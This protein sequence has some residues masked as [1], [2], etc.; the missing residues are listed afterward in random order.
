MVGGVMG[1]E[2]AKQGSRHE[3]RKKRASLST[4]VF[5]GG[6]TITDATIT[7]ASA[8]SN[9][10]TSPAPG[11]TWQKG[12]DTA[13]L[14]CEQNL[15]LAMQQVV[16]CQTRPYCE[17]LSIQLPESGSRLKPWMPSNAFGGAIGQRPSAQRQ[18]CRF[19]LNGPSCP[20]T[21][22]PRRKSRCL[23]VSRKARD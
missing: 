4:P 6:H 16:G 14:I 22:Q 18:F 13:M 19:T 9:H 21:L 1:E 2:E 7:T 5:S 8:V 12:R 10:G 17:P 23:S 3:L 11:R 15:D 20:G